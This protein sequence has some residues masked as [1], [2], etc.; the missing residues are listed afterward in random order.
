MPQGK[1]LIE[2]YGGVWDGVSTMRLDVL[3][4][5]IGAISVCPD[6][7]GAGNQFYTY[8]LHGFMEDPVCPSNSRA[9]YGLKSVDSKKRLAALKIEDL[10][11]DK[12]ATD[13]WPDV[14]EI[15]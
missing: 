1:F 13:Q 4:D 3:P 5:E 7:T 9:Y 15:Y 12:P 14:D 8:E 10:K 2:F 6:G 11:H